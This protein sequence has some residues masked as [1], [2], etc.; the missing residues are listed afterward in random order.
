MIILYITFSSLKITAPDSSA[1]PLAPHPPIL[2]GYIE[3]FLFQLFTLH[4]NQHDEKGNL[5]SSGSVFA[6]LPKTQSLFFIWTRVEITSG[7]SNSVGEKRGCYSRL[8]PYGLLLHFLS[9]KL[10]NF[11]KIHI[12]IVPTF[13]TQ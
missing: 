7:K 1:V 4:H 3:N 13:W 9:L 6:E 11:F 2:F 12:Y 8:T 5:R 10:L